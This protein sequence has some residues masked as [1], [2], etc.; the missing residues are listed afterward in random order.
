MG[1][2]RRPVLLACAGITAIAALS[3]LPQLAQWMAK[4]HG[5]P[6]APANPGLADLAWPT[7]NNGLD[8]QRFSPLQEINAGNVEQS[9]GGCRDSFHHGDLVRLEGRRAVDPDPG[10]PTPVWRPC[11]GMVLR[12]SLPSQWLVSSE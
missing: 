3:Y 4:D 12:H 1:N 10:S 7:Y 9:P 6:A 5:L 8:G 2:R 11:E